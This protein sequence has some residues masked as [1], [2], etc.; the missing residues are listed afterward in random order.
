MAEGSRIVTLDGPGGV[1]KTTVARNVAARLDVAYL[2]TG[3]MFRAVAMAL[4]QGGWELP[5]DELSR[6]LETVRFDL[7]GAG[8]ASVLLVNGQPLP[9]SART[10]E[11]G[12]WASNLGR[13]KVVRSFLKGRQRHIGR[14]RD[15][16]VEGRDMGTVVFPGARHKFFLDASLEERARRRW[17][18]LREQGREEPLQAIR[19]SLGLRDRQ[20]RNR[21]VAPLKPAAD[22]LRIDTT[23][24]SLAEVL[25][26]ILE[27]IAAGR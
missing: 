27:T 13:L 16:V 12:V 4:G 9:E 20:D 3:A 5:E 24:R 14:Q 25:E 2:D 26:L 19:D 1:G 8:D 17:L 6:A 21:A 15:L 10:E 23:R 11:V 18:Q 7:T 22:A